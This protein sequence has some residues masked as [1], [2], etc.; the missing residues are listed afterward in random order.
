MDAAIF[1]LIVADVVARPMDPRRPPERGGL[2][3]LDSISLHTGGNACNVAVAM[4]KLGM[5]VASAGL[6]GDDLFGAAMVERLSAA[7]VDA[8]HVRRDPRA[9]TSATVVAVDPT[10]ERCFF[11]VPGVTSNLNADSFRGCF[12][13]FRQ[14]AWVLIGYFGLLPEALVREL[15]T[16]LGELRATAPGTRVALDTSHPPAK[17]SLLDPILPHLDLFAPSRP[18]AVALTGEKDPIEIV[19]SI[20][21]SM[22]PDAIVGIKLDADG[23]YLDD[24]A[25]RLMLPA[26]RVDVIDTT[27]AGDAWFAGLL[28]GLRKGMPLEQCGKLANRAAADC[29]SALGAS[30]G[31]RSF[32]ETM[33]RL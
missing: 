5:S 33:S 28:T 20:R 12:E 16:L 24:G 18:E 27:G 31:I 22:R 13:L 6:V 23:C 8:S 14:C 4:A 2:S 32:E 25:R 10:G 19:A 29:C 17:R 9:Q 11:H 15:P 21:P 7:K 26:Y 1:G 3:V 30:A